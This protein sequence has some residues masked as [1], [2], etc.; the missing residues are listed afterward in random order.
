MAPTQLHGI[1]HIDVLYSE[2]ELTKHHKVGDVLS[3]AC[4]AASN[5][6]AELHRSAEDL[7]RTRRELSGIKADLHASQVRASSLDAQVHALEGVVQ[8]TVQ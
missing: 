3:H 2:I 8:F 1:Q 5:K 7:E 4:H 6:Q